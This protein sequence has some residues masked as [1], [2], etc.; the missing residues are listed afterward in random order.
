[1]SFTTT[2]S[3]NTRHDKNTEKKLKL[4]CQI[5]YL[6]S[7]VFKDHPLNTWIPCS[8]Q[9]HHHFCPSL[10]QSPLPPKIYNISNLKIFC[11][12]NHFRTHIGKSKFD[13]LHRND[14]ILILAENPECLFEPVLLRTLSLGQHTGEHRGKSRP[15]DLSWP[16]PDL[17]TLQHH[18]LL[19]GVK[20][21]ENRMSLS[22]I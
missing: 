17:V 9:I 15:G 20:A 10:L 2:I 12:S 13:L 14:T 1:M 6:L 16:I 11:W 5:A 21:T 4:I 8:W 19:I 22:T 7:L 3:D 18:L